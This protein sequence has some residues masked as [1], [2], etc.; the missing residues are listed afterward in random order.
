MQD[1]GD[2]ALGDRPVRMRRSSGPVA[3]I[4]RPPSPSLPNFSPPTYNPRLTPLRGDFLSD[5]IPRLRSADLGGGGLVATG[6]WRGSASCFPRER[7][8]GLARS[9]PRR[10]DRQQPLLLAR[11]WAQRGPAVPGVRAASERSGRPLLCDSGARRRCLASDR[12][13]RRCTC[14]HGTQEDGRDGAG[15]GVAAAWTGGSRHRG[16]GRTHRVARASHDGLPG[17]REAARCRGEASDLREGAVER[18]Y[19]GRLLGQRAGPV[20]VHGGG[21]VHVDQEHRVS[22]RARR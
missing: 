13:R 21:S 10:N 1:R 11:C 5:G 9:G 8:G 20:A 18:G 4:H 14:C 22:G 17:R 3:R 2:R 15:G 12:D 16:C 19:R 6:V 7:G